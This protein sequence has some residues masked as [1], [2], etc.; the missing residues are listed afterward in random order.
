MTAYSPTVAALGDTFLVAGV[1]NQTNPH[2]QTPR[3]VRVR[4][5]DGVRLDASPIPIGRYFAVAP[6]VTHLGARWLLTWEEHVSHD[7]P[8]STVVGMFIAP[9]GLAADDFTVTVTGF[10]AQHLPSVTTNS[11]IAVIAWQDVG[12]RTDVYTQ[13]VLPNGTTLDGNGIRVTT[14]ANDQHS[15]ALG[16]DGEAFVVSYVDDRNEG[17]PGIQQFL[18][19]VYASRMNPQ[20]LVMDPDGMVVSR[21]SIMESEP[22]AGGIGGTTVVGCSIFQPGT[23][24]ASYRIGLRTAGPTLSTSVGDRGAVGPLSMSITPN[25]FGSQARIAFTLSRPGSVRAV[26]HDLQ[27][28]ELRK[29]LDAAMPAGPVGLAWDG[30]DA[31][32][33]SMSSGIYLISVAAEGYTM[34]QR[35]ARLR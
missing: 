13:R 26:V 32:G 33:V 18:G 22:I 6:S 29:L 20:G 1:F 3:Y 28:R 11:D 24:F 14:S 27:G 5:S 34:T 10:G 16:W 12:N 25:P 8:A 17:T 9:D 19:D 23:P 31:H 4:G 15:P 30:R 7:N 2:L 21:E 35:I